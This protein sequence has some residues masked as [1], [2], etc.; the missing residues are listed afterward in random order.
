MISKLIKYQQIH[1]YSLHVYAEVASVLSNS[2]Q[3][4]GLY[5]SQLFCPWAS[6]GK[7]TGVGCHLLQWI[8]P[9]PV[10]PPNPEIKPRF[11]KCPAL[12]GRVFTISATIHWVYVVDILFLALT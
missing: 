8:H 6:P 3:P 2:L 11:L 9:P 4:Y 12:T 5:S 7:T 10:D 1:L